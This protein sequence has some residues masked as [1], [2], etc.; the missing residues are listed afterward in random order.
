MIS[1]AASREWGR[2]GLSHYHT[3][4]VVDVP[5]PVTLPQCKRSVLRHRPVGSPY[6]CSRVYER[7]TRSML[8]YVF[9]SALLACLNG[10]IC[11][12]VLKCLSGEGAFVMREPSCMPR[13]D[14]LFFIPEAHSPLRAMRHVA[15][16]EPSQVGRQGLG[17]RGT[18]Q[19]RSPP[20]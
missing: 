11:P 12:H 17:L 5:C 4:R 2:H 7:S 3:A 16:R 15:V 20:E 8:H 19:R 10:V 18:W 1:C 13:S 9:L 14:K 6:H